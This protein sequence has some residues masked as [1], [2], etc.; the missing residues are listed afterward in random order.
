MA[1]RHASERVALRCCA[2]G[3][4]HAL[5]AP[6]Q[7]ILVQ[8]VGD[9]VYAVSNKCPHLGLSMQGKTALLSAKVTPDCCIV[10]PAHNTAFDLATGEVKGEWCPGFPVRVPALRA[11]ACQR[12]IVAVCAARL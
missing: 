10:C 12:H 6:Q 3:F 5:R 9:N 2:Y 1:A 11:C 4:A 8:L 7:K